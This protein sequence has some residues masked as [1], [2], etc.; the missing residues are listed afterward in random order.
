VRIDPDNAARHRSAI[1]SDPAE[2]EVI[3]G[4]VVR[5]TALFSACRTWRYTL[6]REWDGGS[7]T[8]LWLM[9]NPSTAD[10]VRV[11][12][13][14]RRAVTFAMRW[15]K[16]R[17]L[18]GNVFALRATSPEHLYSH[19][20]PVGP[21]NDAHLA[22]MAAQADLIVLA[23]GNHALHG[24]RCRRIAELM[25]PHAAKCVLLA[26]TKSGMPGHPLYIAG[27]TQPKPAA[28]L[29]RELAAR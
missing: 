1:T 3:D 29:L 25:L 8:V 5:G 26:T 7:G 10:A 4:R 23:W 14:V 27:D 13:T 17:A 15:G 24:G 16:A 19:T 11:D 6:V 28:Q 20:D 12:P 9:L 22:A 18:I 21:D 2:P